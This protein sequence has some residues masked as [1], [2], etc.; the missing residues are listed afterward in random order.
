MFYSK[1]H[2]RPSL[3]TGNSSVGSKVMAFDSDYH[4]VPRRVILSLPHC[5]ME[6][7]HT[8]DLLYSL[9]CCIKMVAQPCKDM[10]GSGAL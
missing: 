2:L 3:F 10:G 1:Q 5:L 8:N 7:F 9:C 6:G 4:I